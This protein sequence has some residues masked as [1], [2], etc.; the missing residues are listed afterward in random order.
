VDGGLPTDDPK[1][2]LVVVDREDRELGL[3]TRAD[4]HADPRLL[5]RSVYVTVETA[6]G[7][8]FQRRGRKKDS[9]PGA[10]DLACA[11]HVGA[12]ESYLDAARRELS[13][14]LGLCDVE[15]RRL[16]SLPFLDLDG[17]S[18]LC[19]VFALD[20]DGPFAVRPPE[21]IGVVAFADDERP[22]PL[23]PS[24][25]VVLA[26]LDAQRAEGRSG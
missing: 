13:E 17:E 6:Q 25:R 16:G 15:P 8:L 22:E 3:R 20:H 12:G 2:L 11:G 9:S 23:A 5:H 7:R 18:E 19:T 4:C 26:W 14:E 21:V 24:A 1:E 10:W